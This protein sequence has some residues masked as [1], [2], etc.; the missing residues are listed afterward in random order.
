MRL[1]VPYTGIIMSTRETPEMRK[2]TLDLGV[3][4]VSAGSRTDPGGYSDDGTQDNGQFQLGDH[5]SLDEVI[6]EIAEEGRIPS[7]CTA[8]YRLGRTGKDFMD[9]AKPGLIKEK[10]GPNAV[11]TF[12]EYLLDYAS[13]ETLAAGMNAIEREIAA[14]EPKEQEIARLLVKQVRAGKRDVF[15]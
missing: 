8:C 1:A 3:S 6:K 9:M 14:M 2:A 11:S 7:L 5:R 10:C 4:Q 12:C 13:P 15:C